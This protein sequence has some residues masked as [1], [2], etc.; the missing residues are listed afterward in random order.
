[1]NDL[2]SKDD[3]LYSQH[4]DGKT[5]KIINLSEKRVFQSIPIEYDIEKII[6]DTFE[7]IIVIQME[8]ELNFDQP[9]RSIVY[10][11]IK[12]GVNY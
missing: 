12:N 6:Y 11:I 5:L 4:Y 7:F 10:K 1:M 8:D 3:S 9:D 2:N